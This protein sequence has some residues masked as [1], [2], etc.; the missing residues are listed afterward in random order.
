MLYLPPNTE[1]ASA[2]LEASAPAPAPEAE[3]DAED[4][5]RIWHLATD[6]ER[7][8]FVRGNLIPIWDLIEHVTA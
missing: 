2:E 8:A 1:K 4:L 3:A 7:R 6:K 5:G